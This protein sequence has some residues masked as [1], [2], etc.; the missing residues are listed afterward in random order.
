MSLD[1]DHS[2]AISISGDLQD[3]GD[4]SAVGALVR[5]C[6]L[7][8]EEAE[9]LVFED[10]IGRA[11]DAKDESISNH[12]KHRSGIY[13]NESISPQL[14]EEALPVNSQYTTLTRS[15]S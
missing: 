5:L 3:R 7:T 10:Q 2:N 13:I 1:D 11:D 9:M 8:R 15:E 4:K 6:G 12:S 14:S